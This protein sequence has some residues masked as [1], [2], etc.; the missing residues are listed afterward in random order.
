MQRVGTVLTLKISGVA[1]TFTS[2]NDSGKSQSCL[3]VEKDRDS[4]KVIN[5]DRATQLIHG[6][7]SAIQEAT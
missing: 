4:E 6:A 5:L 1:F 7:E 2:Q 3:T